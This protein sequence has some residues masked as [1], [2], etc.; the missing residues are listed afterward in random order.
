MCSFFENFWVIGW[1]RLLL[2]EIGVGDSVVGLVL[3]VN[4]QEYLQYH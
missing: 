2:L 3:D 1:L 4:S